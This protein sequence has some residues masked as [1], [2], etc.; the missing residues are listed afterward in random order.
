MR[1]HGLCRL[2]T[3]HFNFETALCHEKSNYINKT[4]ERKCFSL[5]FTHDKNISKRYGKRIEQIYLSFV[6]I[7]AF[8]EISRNII[9]LSIEYQC[10]E[11][12]P[13]FSYVYFGNHIQLADSKFQQDYLFF[14][15][16]FNVTS[17]IMLLIIQGNVNIILI[18]IE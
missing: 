7:L 4:I 9:Y 13:D 17:T 15:V 3:V 18:S 6:Q 16:E 10:S 2:T 8:R 14:K 12:E 11:V 5:Q 1:N